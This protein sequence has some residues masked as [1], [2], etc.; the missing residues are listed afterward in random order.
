MAEP[1]TLIGPFFTLLKSGLTWLWN[2]LR[3]NR[4]K[5]GV[6]KQYS[7]SPDGGMFFSSI[8]LENQGPFPV[9]ITGVFAQEENLVIE[10]WNSPPHQL[11]PHEV[12]KW[13]VQPPSV[14]DEKT[15]QSIYDFSAL[16][17]MGIYVRTQSKLVKCTEII[18]YNPSSH[19]DPEVLKASI[20]R[21]S[22]QGIPY[23]DFDLYGVTFLFNG[24]LVSVVIDKAGIPNKY[25]QSYAIR[26]RPE[27]LSSVETVE[28]YFLN[29]FRSGASVCRLR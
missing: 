9:W 5:L 12:Y 26:L 3:L 10:L 14:I 19:E 13:E 18:T 4:P 25:T 21:K 1:V 2:L 29:E 11:G 15:H 7:N 6:M 23:G 27:Q 20:I 16:S 17:H 22:Y 28:Q 24:E 8:T